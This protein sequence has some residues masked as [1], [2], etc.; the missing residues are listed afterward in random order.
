MT[1][2]TLPP[3]TGDPEIDQYNYDVYTALING[4]SGSVDEEDLEDYIKNEDGALMVDDVTVA[5]LFRYLDVA[6]G[7]DANGADFSD[8]IIDL[9]ANTTPVF[10]GRRNTASDEASNNPT[11]FSW[12]EINSETDSATLKSYYKLLGGKQI[13]FEFGTTLPEGYTEHEGE[14]IDLEA[15]G[16]NGTN[17]LNAAI[18]VIEPSNG[19]VFKLGGETTT[20]LTATVYDGGSRADDTAHS[21]FHYTWKHKDAV[22]CIGPSRNVIEDPDGGPLLATGGDGLWV[23]STGMPA[24]NNIADSDDTFGGALRRIIVGNED[25]DGSA[26]FVV[27]VSNIA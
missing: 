3:L 20:T 2:I 11:A 23:C 4:G 13:D 10:I 14:V 26:Q 7:S 16:A 27:E 18:C 17:G 1:D 19:T 25:V 22:I 12:A 21:N 15:T 6:Y 9:P 24:D 5:Y 8:E